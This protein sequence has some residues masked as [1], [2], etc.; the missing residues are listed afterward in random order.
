MFARWRLM[1]DMPLGGSFRLWVTGPFIRFEVRDDWTIVII[2]RRMGILGRRCEHHMQP[3]EV[4][5]QRA[6]SR[7]HSNGFRLDIANGDVFYLWC[8]AALAGHIVSVL[9]AAGA[10]VLSGEFDH[11]WLRVGVED[12]RS[13]HDD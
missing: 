11:D 7:G 1:G 9:G 8:S 2:W 13:R 10:E 4:T 5:V 12:Y 3:D 6:R